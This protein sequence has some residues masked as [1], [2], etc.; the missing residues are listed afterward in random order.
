MCTRPDQQTLRDI[1]VQRLAVLEPRLPRLSIKLAPDARD[2]RLEVLRDDVLLGAVS[3]GTPLP[4]NPGKHV[5]VVRAEGRRDRSFEI[6]L[7]EGEQQELLVAP[8]DFLVQPP[9]P[10]ASA[11]AVPALEA[12]PK[13]SPAR[14]SGSNGRR[15]VALVTGGAG[16]LS[17]ATGSVFALASIVEYGQSNA[18]CNAASQCHPGDA[19][20]E[21]AHAMQHGDFATGFIG[22]GA[23]LVAAGAIVW[24][25]AP[26]NASARTARVGV[27]PAVGP[28]GGSFELGGTW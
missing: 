22:A 18:G 19:Y 5:V 15:T 25:T 11:R 3:L 21:R 12:V 27:M 26:T 1:A 17:I 10:E 20:T 7:A 2:A 8:G 6:S 13:E 23:A 14:P 4:T 16:I 9:V 24:L 28:A